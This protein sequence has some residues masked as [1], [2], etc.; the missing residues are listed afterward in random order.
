MSKR[1]RHV[2]LINY[3]NFF[4][5]ISISTDLIALGITVG[6]SSF[7]GDKR[8]DIFLGIDIFI[9]FITIG[10]RNLRK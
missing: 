6:S 5:E 1:I 4:C 2:S 10:Y 7:K 9:L 3:G 8:D